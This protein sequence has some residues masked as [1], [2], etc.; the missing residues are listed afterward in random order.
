[1]ALRGYF[2]FLMVLGGILRDSL[3]RVFGGK[4]PKGGYCYSHTAGSGILVNSSYYFLILCSLFYFLMVFY[5]WLHNS[6]T[7]HYAL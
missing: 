7:L 3:L 6:V 1:M 5:L 4:I 2:G